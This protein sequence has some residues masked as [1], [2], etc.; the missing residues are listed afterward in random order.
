MENNLETSVFKNL[1]L[2]RKSCDSTEKNEDQNNEENTDKLINELPKF[3]S[4]SKNN[5]DFESKKIYFYEIY[6]QNSKMIQM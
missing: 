6:F 1:E 4:V 5:F 3:E 2:L